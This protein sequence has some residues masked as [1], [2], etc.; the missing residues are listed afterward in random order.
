MLLAAIIKEARK[1]RE[2]SLREVSRLTKIS[3]ALL[4]YIETGRK[5][6]PKMEILAKLSAFYNIPIDII[7]LAATRIPQDCFY[8]IIRCPSLLQVIRD[9]PE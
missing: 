7:C 5:P 6:R 8:K 9:Y 3:L 4:C 1:N 2:L